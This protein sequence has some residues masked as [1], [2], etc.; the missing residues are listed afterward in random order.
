MANVCE[1]RISNGGYSPIKRDANFH[2][3]FIRASEIYKILWRVFATDRFWSY[4]VKK[5]IFVLMFG[6][7]EEDSALWDAKVLLL[8]KISGIKSNESQEFAF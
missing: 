6:G 5:N 8:Y 4:G 7:G 3:G 1:V 2:N